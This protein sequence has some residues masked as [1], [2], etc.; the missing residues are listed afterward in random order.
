M[1]GE[2][3][4]LVP[5]GIATLCGIGMAVCRGIMLGELQGHLSG[6]QA[7]EF[8]RLSWNF[9]RIV[10]MHKEFYPQSRVPIVCSV[11]KYT[12]FV[13]MLGIGIICIYY[14]VLNP[15]RQ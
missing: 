9:S 3:L 12:A 7:I 6:D 14:A 11:L 13:C 15:A 5:L 2:L 10:R 8:P 4:V 1:G